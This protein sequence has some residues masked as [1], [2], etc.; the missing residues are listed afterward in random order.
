MRAPLSPVRPFNRTTFVKKFE[1][2]P[3]V[4]LV[5]RYFCG[6]DRA[7]IQ[8]LDEIR[9][10]QLLREAGVLRDRRYDQRRTDR[11]EHFVL[12]HFHHARVRAEKLA[13]G[14]RMRERIAPHNG[15]SQIDAA[16]ERNFTRTVPMSSGRIFRASNF[17]I[18]LDG[19]VDVVS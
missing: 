17:K 15:W 5:P 12:W 1:H 8:S 13:V 16:V 6:W 10:E 9:V 11:F 14:E 18:L 3:F 4:R 2:V 19:S 7:Q